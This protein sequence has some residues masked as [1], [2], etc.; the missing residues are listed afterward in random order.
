MVCGVF[1]NRQ[2]H[3]HVDGNVSTSELPFGWTAQTNIGRSVG[4]TRGAFSE[5]NGKSCKTL[6]V[7]AQ[8]SQAWPG[9]S[10]VE[11]IRGSGL[12]ERGRRNCEVFRSFVLGQQR[13]KES[14]ASLGA[15][16]FQKVMMDLRR[17]IPT[18]N[19]A[20]DIVEIEW[21]SKRAGR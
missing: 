16:N 3:D 15:R 6:L 7:E 5:G 17:S 2:R 11:A 20:L 14:P 10:D 1:V 12:P 8:R 4:P 19:V 18:K 21:L 13:C 9:Q